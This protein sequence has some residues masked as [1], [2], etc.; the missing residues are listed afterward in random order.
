MIYIIMI[1]FDA[2]KYKILLVQAKKYLII[3]FICAFTWKKLKQT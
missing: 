3:L 2:I 1:E